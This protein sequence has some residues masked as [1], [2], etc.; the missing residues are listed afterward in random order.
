MLAIAI[1]RI[2]LSLYFAHKSLGPLAIPLAVLGSS[3]AS[4]I[5]YFSI[6]K[7]QMDFPKL[8]MIRNNFKLRKDMT[9]AR[10]IQV[11]NERADYLVAQWFMPVS[12]IGI[13]NKAKELPL[14][15]RPILGKPMVTL[16]QLRLRQEE[17]V[18]LRPIL[19]QH[20][21]MI[22]LFSILII[23]GK[24]FV[25]LY[26]GTGWELVAFYIPLGASVLAL[27]LTVSLDSYFLYYKN[28][29][30]IVVT[31]LL[32][33]LMVKVLFF[34]FVYQ[35][36]RDLDILLL[37]LFFMHALEVISYRIKIYNSLPKKYRKLTTNIM[38][39]WV[40]LMLGYGLMRM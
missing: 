7:F 3:I 12:Y 11:L 5:L 15:V 26:M 36:I 40:I 2:I 20:L 37:L 23:F 31:S 18:K 35:I 30:D 13:L 6:T 25:L 8:K 27:R 34:V 16:T 9:L 24:N 10:L 28:Q 29:G 39:L 22:I 14:Q 33:S 19:Y 1:V 4:G 17:E 38:A 21:C 32:F